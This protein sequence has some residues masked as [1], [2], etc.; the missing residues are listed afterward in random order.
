MQSKTIET[1]NSEQ[2]IDRIIL[3][4]ADALVKV[5]SPWNGASQMLCQTLQGLASTYAGKVNF[6]AL[7]S[8]SESSL[9]TTYRV[10][11]IPTILFFKKG[12]L[13]DRLSGLTHRTT[14]SHKILQLI[15]S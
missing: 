4:K 11:V 10:D 1:I 9:G 8:E 2:F 3:R 14:I 15:N 5:S 13:V 12:T 7:D 6:F